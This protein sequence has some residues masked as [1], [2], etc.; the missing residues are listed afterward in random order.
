[1]RSLSL[2][3][4]LCVSS[5]LELQAGAA[6]H[7]IL[8]LG[9]TVKANG[10]PSASLSRRLVTAR[11]LALSDRDAVV[12]VSGGTRGGKWKPEGEVMSRWLV[13]HGVA[14][15]RIRVEAAATNTAEN[16]DLSAPILAREH[17]QRVTV[18][19]ERFHMR[20]ALFH[21]HAALGDR[22]AIDGA[23]APD[24]LF[25]AAR[26]KRDTEETQKIER[27]RA[28]RAAR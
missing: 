22:V 12:V 17:V 28:F 27:D 8:V 21:V 16:A 9:S 14:K 26:R 20:R 11:A 2:L 3:F 13:A 4:V 19:T 15:G 1:M 10:R 23:S 24:G 25:G 18:V 5:T 6:E 7:A